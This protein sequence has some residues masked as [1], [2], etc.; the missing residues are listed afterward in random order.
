MLSTILALSVSFAPASSG[1]GSIPWD[2]RAAEHLL[3]RAGFGARPPEVEAAVAAGL[4]ATVQKLLDPPQDWEMPAYERID[5]PT[6]K[7][8]EGLTTDEQNRLKRE[9]RERDRRQL[10]ESTG[11]WF[12]RMRNGDAPLL[13]KMTLFWHGV[14]TTSIEETKRGFLVLQQHEFL[15]RNALGSYADLLRGIV[16]DPAMLVYLDNNVNRKGSPNENLARELMELFSL[17]EGNYTEEDVK[18]AARA[19]TGRGV[20]REG[21]YEF[22]ARQHDDGAKTVLGKTGKLD[23]DQLVDV[24]L[25]QEAC[26]RWVARRML[27]WFEGVE[28]DKT[29]LAEYAAFLRKNDFRVKPFLQKLFTDPRFYRDEI[30]G[31]RVLSPIEY[32]VGTAR[33]L[34]VDAPPAVLGA[35]AALLGQRVFSPPSVKGWDE[36]HAWIST[37]S[38]MQRGNLSGFLLGVV[39]LQDVMST[40]DVEAQMAA[41]SQPTMQGD[42]AMQAKREDAQPP[43]RDGARPPPPRGASDAP[44]S[45][46]AADAPDAKKP[47][48]RKGGKPGGPALDVLRRIENSGWYPALNLRVRMEK[49]GAR[50]DAEIVDRMLD[51]LLAIRAPDD[52]RARMRE[53]LATERVQRKLEEGKFLESGGEAERVL[54]RLA[55]LILSLPEAQLG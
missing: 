40:A 37:S 50:T 18:E 29:R 16:R 8:L 54:R 32:M 39:K 9:A 27:T 4:E 36:G 24:L 1:T 49:A 17:G 7:E 52:T 22:R 10:L 38:F 15:R 35:G 5:E 13:E 53:Y 46:A 11:W 31:A 45:R 44:S 47:A 33:R 48:P 14:F 41:E 3:N 34:N 42:D 23:G 25:A 21:R 6:K 55:H 30:V 51:D 26:P 2:A 43:M 19:L 28:P 20:D 12:G